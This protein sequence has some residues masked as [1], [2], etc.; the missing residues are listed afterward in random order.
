MQRLGN[1]FMRTI[2][3]IVFT[4]AMGWALAGCA[5]NGALSQQGHNVVGAAEGWHEGTVVVADFRGGEVSF[6]SPGRAWKP[7]SRGLVLSEGAG[8][9]TGP[10]ASC[11]IRLGA[12]GRSL[13]AMPG[14]EVYFEQLRWLRSG[15]H[16]NAM[17]IVRL[18]AGRVVGDSGKLPPGD[19][20]LVRLP[21]G[22]EIDLTE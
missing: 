5:N 8:L 11:D 12:N 20:V 6:N 19:K 18:A 3:Y 17:T 10:E 21:N 16:T 7:A 22:R 15:A 9:K 2:G 4:V 1:D 14:S 13:R